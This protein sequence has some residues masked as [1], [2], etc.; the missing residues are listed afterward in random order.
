MQQKVSITEWIQQKKRVCELEDRNLKIVVSEENRKKMK[1]SRERVEKN[2]NDL[3]YNINRTNLQIIGIPEREEKGERKLT[4]GKK[5]AEDFPKQG[6]DLHIQQGHKDHR[7][8]N[9]IH[10]NRFSPRHIIIKL[11]KNFYPSV[12]SCGLSY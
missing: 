2:E 9:K 1:M 12:C 8:Q 10:L 3:W 7:S 5:M 4:S 6:K 11:S